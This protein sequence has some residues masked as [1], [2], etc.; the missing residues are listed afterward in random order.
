[1]TCALR[2]GTA[3]L[4]VKCDLST[5]MNVLLRTSR[6]L[7]RNDTTFL[8]RSLLHAARKPLS[9]RRSCRA[10]YSTHEAPT[11]DVTRTAS[12]KFGRVPRVKAF[13]FA[14]LGIVPSLVKTIKTV[15]PHIDKPTL[16]QAEFIPAILNNKDVLLQDE[17][18]TGK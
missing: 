18:G 16:S 6:C 5:R 7:Y 1:M 17:T 10:V 9:A 13:G 4:D 15:F 14:E 12:A 8:R 11:P 3:D 2:R